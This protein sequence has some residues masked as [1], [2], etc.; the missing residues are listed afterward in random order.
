MTDKII[1]LGVKMEHHG[2]QRR[3]RGLRSSGLDV[4]A[5]AYQRTAMKP[6]A[7]I[8]SLGQ[9]AEEAGLVSRMAEMRAAQ[10]VLRKAVPQLGRV[11][12]IYARNLD[13]A[14]SAVTIARHLPEPVPIIY[15]VLDIHPAM[16]GSGVKARFLRAVE[17]YVLRHARGVVVSSPNFLDGYFRPIQGYGGK[18]FLMENKINGLDDCQVCAPTSIPDT[19]P[20][21][22]TFSGIMRCAK[23]LRLLH[24]LA[25]KRP[26]TVR[27][28]LA[29]T[30]LA[31]CKADH[32]RLTSL[33][34]V[35]NIGAYTYPNDLWKIFDGAHLNWTMDFYDTFN[36]PLLI[37]NRFYEGGIFC[38]PALVRDGSGTGKRAADWGIGI[39]MRE[40]YE[41][42]L[43]SVVDAPR[44][45]LRA[46]R[47]RMA[48]LPK[49]AF[50][51]IDDHAR[52]RDFILNAKA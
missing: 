32:D 38:V 24:G 4:A 27:I 14:V 11:R 21:T 1:Y 44:D 52:L 48:A 40:P 35:E 30:P 39:P 7:G 36:S 42:S 2:V 12:A 41:Q 23:S 46:E 28:R 5:F 8:H 31:Y 45:R 9:A 13:L 22:I 16:A 29:G 3:I 47:D 19:G 33:P 49:G 6:V 43:L 37:P 50:F 18:T 15:E 25:L 10:R 17:R 26:E 51:D 20:L 34:N